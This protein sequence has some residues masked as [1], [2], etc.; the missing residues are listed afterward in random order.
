MRHINRGIDSYRHILDYNVNQYYYI[1]L[2]FS[3]GAVAMSCVFGD[4]ILNGLCN[5]KYYRCFDLFSMAV[6]GCR[7]FRRSA[8]GFKLYSVALLF[9]NF[10]AIA[11]LLDTLMPT[12][13]ISLLNKLFQVFFFLP[14]RLCSFGF[15]WRWKFLVWKEWN[16]IVNMLLLLLPV[17]RPNVG[18]CLFVVR[19]NNWICVFMFNELLTTF[20]LHFSDLNG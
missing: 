13:R 12:C 15:G 11:I 4:I 17:E 8:A 3:F 1:W 19:A 18:C 16:W 10:H 20:W 6:L 9:H 5:Q 2:F 7:L 14:S